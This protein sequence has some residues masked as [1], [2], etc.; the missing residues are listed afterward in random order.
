[1]GYEACAIDDIIVED[2][3]NFSRLIIDEFQ[4]NNI[5]RRTTYILF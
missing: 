4:D 1:M 3:G 5:M 2:L